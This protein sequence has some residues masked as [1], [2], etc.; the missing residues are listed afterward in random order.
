MDKFGEGLVGWQ[1]GEGLARYSERSG[2]LDERIVE[3]TIF[4]V[5]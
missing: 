2:S 4:S 1:L 3:R 5:L